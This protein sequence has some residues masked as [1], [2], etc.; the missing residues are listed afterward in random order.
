MENFNLKK[1]LVENKLTTNSK[2]LSEE[3]EGDITSMVKGFY[4]TGME[5]GD[6]SK[7][8]E[9]ISNQL[10][11][12]LTPIEKSKITKEFEN[13][14]LADMSASD[15]NRRGEERNAKLQRAQKN[16][17]PLELDNHSYT[18][19][20]RYY[21]PHRKSISGVGGTI[22]PMNN[23]DGTTQYFLKDEF[24]NTPITGTIQV[25]GKEYSI[26]DF[27]RNFYQGLL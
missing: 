24:K 26:P 25:N 16:M 2:M 27:Y 11:R 18:P 14:Y 21:E 13:L 6:S 10:N 7:A 9:S 17:L 3:Q 20:P 22:I 4:K 1:F 23:P 12:P 5:M 15:S 8:K 19:D